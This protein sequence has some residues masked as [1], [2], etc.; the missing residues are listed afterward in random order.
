MIEEIVLTVF[1]AICFMATW[2]M[3]GIS[4]LGGF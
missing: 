3:V 4:I 1:G 2:Y